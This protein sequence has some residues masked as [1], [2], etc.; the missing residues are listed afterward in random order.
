MMNRWIQRLAATVLASMLV[1]CG[2]GAGSGDPLPGAT[3]TDPTTP[4]AADL[5]ISLSSTSV[6][7]SGS[8]SVVAT[9][10]AVDALYILNVAIE[11]F[12]CDVEVCDV[13]GNGAIAS[14]DSLLCLRHSVGQTVGFSCP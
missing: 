8:E 1:A 12:S 5:S 4:T 2:G 10:T 13:N 9:V 7:N 11:L 6:A 14:A 3:P